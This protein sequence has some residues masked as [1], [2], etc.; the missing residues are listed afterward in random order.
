MAHDADMTLRVRPAGPPDA[1]AALDLSRRLR[2]GV[3]PWRDTEAVAGIV[4]GWVE[5]SI[6]AGDDTT[7]ACYVAEDR[8][9]DRA[10][11]GADDGAEHGEGD[12]EEGATVLGFI[13]V[14]RST[15]WTGTVEAYI[16]EL[17]V[18]ESAEGQGVGRALVDRAAAWGRS[19]GCER[20]ALDTGAANTKAIG[21]YRAIDFEA[22]EVRLSRP[23]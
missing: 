16:G 20:I 6:G 23:L 15:H 9:D 2:E 21:F 10:D 13:S 17:M 14:E 12:G 5:A 11:D 19:H 3:S 22:D 1:P 7:K 4:R 18:D 8:A